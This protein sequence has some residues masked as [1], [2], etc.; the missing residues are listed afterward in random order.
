MKTLFFRF[1]TIFQNILKWSQI[2]IGLIKMY[3]FHCISNISIYLSRWALGT[4]TRRGAS[5]KHS[6]RK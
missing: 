1:I 4:K 5:L 2:C 3:S 6:K